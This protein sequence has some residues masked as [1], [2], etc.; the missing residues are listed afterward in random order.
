MILYR[1]R[2]CILH[3]GKTPRGVTYCQE[4]DDGV[5]M[6][7]D[8]KISLTPQLVDSCIDG[9]RYTFSWKWQTFL[10][11]FNF[12][13]SA[14]VTSPRRWRWRWWPE[15]C[16]IESSTMCTPH[17]PVVRCIEKF[18]HRLESKRKREGKIARRALCL[19][20]RVRHLPLLL[21]IA[22]RNRSNGP[23]WLSYSRK[24]VFYTNFSV[25]LL[26]CFL[27]WLLVNIR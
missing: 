12:G 2:A 3:T 25:R 4:Y 27:Y 8:P 16:P 20:G 17:F 26:L 13:T 15:L 21:C 22:V 19:R 10:H 5:F 6:P 18:V 7:G 9:W 23:G 14:R 24:G 11:N 1:P